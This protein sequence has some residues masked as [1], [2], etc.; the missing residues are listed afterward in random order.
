MI[1]SSIKK[2]LFGGEVEIVI[3]DVEE[4]L[5]KDM[6]ESAYDEGLRLQ[7]IFNFYD[8]ESELSK[9]NKK[10]QLKVSKQF[11][12]V[13]NTALRFCELTKG[14]YDISLG[15]AI[16]QRKSGHKDISLC[17]SYK[18]I[19]I[20][21]DT[22]ALAHEDVMIDLGS[23]AKGYIAD[24]MADYLKSKGVLSGIIDARGDIVIFGDAEQ[25]IDVQHPRNSN[26]KLKSIT[27]KNL[28]VATSGDYR[29]YVLDYDHSH[30]LNKKDVISVTVVAPSLMIADVYASVLFVGDREKIMSM[31]QAKTIKAMTVNSNMDIEYFNGFEEL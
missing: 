4:P 26:K 16:I 21:D 3:F 2:K 25:K 1:E 19:I 20:K 17:C 7:K 30:I 15:K 14:E 11:L 29:Q 12:E 10:R 31:P 8:K 28:C 5:A 18:D 22:V 24:K 27:L 6:L 9:L 23:I 13:I